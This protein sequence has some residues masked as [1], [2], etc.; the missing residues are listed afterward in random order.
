[1]KNFSRWGRRK[2]G[3]PIEKMEDG[4]YIIFFF[5]L[6]TPGDLLFRFER[7]CAYSEE[8][9]RVMTIKVPQRKK[10]IDIEP[11]VPSP[12]YLSEFSMKLRPQ[13]PRRGGGDFRRR[14]YGDRPQ[15]PGRSNYDDRRGDDR[16]G[17]DPPAEATPVVAAPA[18]D[19]EE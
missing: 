6:A 10:G 3:Y 2:L 16:R 18:G 13:Y 5:T 12:G 17:D 14:S 1:M 4:F 11:I 8:I 19:S 7:K 9:L 15:S